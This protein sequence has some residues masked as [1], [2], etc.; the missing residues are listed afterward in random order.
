ML[1]YFRN[2]LKKLA[3]KK[4]G[5][6]IFPTKRDPNN[7]IDQSGVPDRISAQ[8]L[9]KEGKIPLQFVC[10]KSVHLF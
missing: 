8:H 7:H 4:E 2:R 5:L 3:K 9:D 10:K 6:D 1:F